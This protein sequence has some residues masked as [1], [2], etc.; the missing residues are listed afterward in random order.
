MVD[1]RSSHTG[2]VDAPT[3]PSTGAEALTVSVVIPC[4]NVAGT[5][6]AQ[7]DGLEA[8]DYSGTIEVL[9][10]DNGSTDATAQVVAPFLARHPTWRIVDASA[11]RGAN[12]A[13]NAGW[14]AG[15]GTVVL[16]CDGDDIVKPGWVAA[17]VG[18][19]DDGAD[20]VGGSFDVSSLNPPEVAATRGKPEGLPVYFGYLPSVIG[21]NFAVRRRVLEALDGFDESFVL[22]GDE[23][24]FAWRAQLAGHT[25]AHAPDAEVAYRYRASTKAFL[26]QRWNY[27][28]GAVKLY[29]TF[30]DKGMRRPKL[31]HTIRL[32]GRSA[33]TA[34]FGPS[35]ARLKATG[36]LVSLAGHLRTSMR[37]RTFFF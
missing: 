22:G 34:A 3:S 6:A 23:I 13:R 35:D 30:R 2:P 15:S 1:A 24:E 9:L 8:Q 21:A 27:S 17:M 11:T 33:K 28:G 32:A 12:A 19:F 10:A 36:E 5:I 14:R 16:F 29:I 25:I 7:L 31:T 37:L 18:A 20:I 4:L 26:K